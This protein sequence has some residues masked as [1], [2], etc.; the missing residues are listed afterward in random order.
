MMKYNEYPIFNILNDDG[1]I[2]LAKKSM[3][4]VSVSDIFNIFV[5]VI[6]QDIKDLSSN[7]TILIHSNHKKRY[8]SVI[9]NEKDL[10]TGYQ[11]I[12]LQMNDNDTSSFEIKR[13]TTYF[14]IINVNKG[15][16]K[17]QT[18]EPNQH[19][20]LIY[21]I[22]KTEILNHQIKYNTGQNANPTIVYNEQSQ[23]LEISTSKTFVIEHPLDM[24]KYLVH[25][26]LEGPESGIYYRGTDQIE[27]GQFYKEISLPSYVSKLGTNFTIS[28]SPILDFYSKLS[29]IEN[30]SPI[31][32]VS[33][34][35][36]NKFRVFGRS[37]KFY[38]HAFAKREN[39]QVEVSKS[40][41]NIQGNGPYKWI[42]H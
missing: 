36:E 31:I 2:N 15:F 24:N 35:L 29:D 17:T 11:K 38:W 4:I 27:E 34:V 13:N 26:C 25:A 7:D 20:I 21:D 19:T 41:T 23:K 9:S 39:I 3:E 6:D 12:K 37:T 16:V 42:N 40:N 30:G 1:S 5:S 32:G 14:T 33:E 22:S 28:V 10:F 8:F 18:F